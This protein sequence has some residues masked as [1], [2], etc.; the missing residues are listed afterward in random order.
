EQLED[1][2][3]AAPAAVVAPLRRAAALPEHVAGRQVLAAPVA[4]GEGAAQHGVEDVE[5]A[6]G[7]GVPVLGGEEGQGGAVGGQGRDDREGGDGARVGADVE[8]VALVVDLGDDAHRVGAGAAQREV[9]LRVGGAVGDDPALAQQLD[10]DEAGGA[11]LDGERGAARARA[12]GLVAHLP[13]GGDEGGVLG[14][15]PAALAG[16]TACV[17]ALRHLVAGHGAGEQLPF[18]SSTRT[19]RHPP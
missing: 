9:A 7:A 2:P 12:A 16:A 19:T 10:P 11:A 5:G 1:V 13:L 17:H 8:A 15:G 3:I 18:L 4:H 14:G 6:R